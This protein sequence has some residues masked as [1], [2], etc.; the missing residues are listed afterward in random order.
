MTVKKTN[1]KKAPER[2]A[3]VDA[4]VDAAHARGFEAYKA[5][6]VAPAQSPEAAELDAFAHHLSEV[7]R[8]ARTSPLISPGFY[9][10]LADAWNN[11]VNEVLNHTAGFYE[12][13]AYIRLALDTYVAAK[14]GQQAEGG[15]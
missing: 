8:I 11:S 15:E 10:T 7:L 3:G 5:A 14:A 1:T 4:E 2:K 13:E 12:S 6:L 9:N